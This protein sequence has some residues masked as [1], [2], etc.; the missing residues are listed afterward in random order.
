MAR[1]ACTTSSLHRAV[2]A[3][4]TCPLQHEALR[5]PPNVPTLLCSEALK[6]AHEYG[7]LCS[8]GEGLEIVRFWYCLAAGA[9]NRLSREA[10]SWRDTMPTCT[11]FACMWQPEPELTAP[12][13]P[14]LA[15]AID[16]AH[17]VSEWGHGACTVHCPC[18]GL[19]GRAP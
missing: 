16:E 4:A 3:A 7:K 6:V 10:H 11:L 17:C 13:T 19:F 5:F 18:Y 8:F 2:G 15:A 1:D 12:Y 14:C 9:C